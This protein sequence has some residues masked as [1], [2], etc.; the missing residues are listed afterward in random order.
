MMRPPIDFWFD[1]ASPYG[2]FMAEKIEVVAGRHGRR[3]R[4]RP[5]ILFAVLRALDLPPPMGH[6]V[7]R[8]YMQ[9]DFER[10]ARF[11]DVP[12]RIPAG[13]PAVTQHAARAFYLL[14]RL[15]PSLA[16]N[17]ARVA[18]RSYFV[19]GADL[20]DA[21]QVARWAC[22]AH[23]ALGAPADFVLRMRADD[24]RAML[25]SAVDEAVREQVFG[26][27]TVVIDGERFFGV[28]RLP[29]IEACLAGTL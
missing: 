5:V 6:E 27:P 15:E 17:F 12:F 23:P 10:S 13:F 3:V 1:F 8:A 7:K 24:A 16:I 21:M 20:G 29:Q 22:E 9:L 4:W 18:L 26:S 28:D 2:Y 25:A 19:Q 11:L 14:E